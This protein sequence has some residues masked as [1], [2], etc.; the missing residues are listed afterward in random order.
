MAKLGCH[1]LPDLAILFVVVMYRHQYSDISSSFL[2]LPVV[3]QI[4]I[5]HEHC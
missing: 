5:L 3:V 2:T 4:I 1:N